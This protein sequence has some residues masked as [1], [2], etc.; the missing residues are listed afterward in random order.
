VRRRLISDRVAALITGP[1][2]FLVAGVIDLL[3][4]AASSL[5]ARIHARHRRD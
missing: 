1:I 4:F 2:A 5:Q 3:V